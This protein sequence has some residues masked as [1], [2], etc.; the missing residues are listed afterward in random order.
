[1]FDGLVRCTNQ[2][3][4]RWPARKCPGF[5]NSPEKISCPGMA[6]F[7]PLRLRLAGAI[8]AESGVIHTESIETCHENLTNSLNQE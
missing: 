3:K 6:I 7:R 2:E 1:M 5:R 4:S 8:P